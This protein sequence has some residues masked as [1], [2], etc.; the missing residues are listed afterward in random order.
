MVSQVKFDS[1]G[2]NQQKRELK[3]EPRDEAEGSQLFDMT[4]SEGSSLKSE[5]D[6][7]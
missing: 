2:T 5:D 4:N 7:V 6:Q 3:N 1:S